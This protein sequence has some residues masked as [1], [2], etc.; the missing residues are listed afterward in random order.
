MPNSKPDV[1]GVHFNRWNFGGDVLVEL[2]DGAHTRV[3]INVQEIEAVIEA[4]RPAL[5]RYDAMIAATFNTNKE[6]GS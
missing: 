2:P 3:P 1:A 4:I 6:E 5:V